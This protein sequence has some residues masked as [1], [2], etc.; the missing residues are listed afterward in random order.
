MKMPGRSTI[1]VD[2]PA[3]A[4]PSPK[5]PSG[6]TYMLST[7][8]MLPRTFVKTGRVFEQGNRS[9]IACA[10]ISDHAPPTSLASCTWHIPSPGRLPAKTLSVSNAKPHAATASSSQASAPR[11]C[12]TQFQRSRMI[13]DILACHF[14]ARICD[15]IG[16]P[17]A[18][19]KWLLLIFMLG[20]WHGRAQDRRRVRRR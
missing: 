5:L 20:I 17:P 11:D 8:V 13:D 7:L 15:L 10:A 9:R 3:C 16:T 1:T 2:A 18:L 19:K 14:N 12:L 6:Y 4:A